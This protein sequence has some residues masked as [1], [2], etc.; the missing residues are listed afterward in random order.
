MGDGTVSKIAKMKHGLRGLIGESHGSFNISKAY[1]IL[2]SSFIQGRF[3]YKLYSWIGSQ[4]SVDMI[5][6]SEERFFLF[7]FLFIYFFIYCFILFLFNF[8]FILFLFY[9]FYFIIFILLFFYIVNF[10]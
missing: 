2:H 10:I 8:C 7:I 1:V 3:N 9:Y 5:D 4:T 6:Q